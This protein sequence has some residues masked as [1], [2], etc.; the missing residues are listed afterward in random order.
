MT[1]FTRLL[2]FTRK[3]H[4]FKSQETPDREA[5][6]GDPKYD[7]RD[8]QSKIKYCHFFSDFSAVPVGQK[9]CIGGFSAISTPGR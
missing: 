5:L 6:L 2:P 9:S 8:P 4:F 1:F 7:L 3:S